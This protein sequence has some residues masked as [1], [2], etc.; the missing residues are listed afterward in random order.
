M[1]LLFHWSDPKDPNE[2]NQKKQRNQIDER[3]EIPAVGSLAC[4]SFLAKAA[5]PMPSIDLQFLFGTPFQSGGLML[6]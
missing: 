5:L 6:W 2:P 3:N 1:H 4:R